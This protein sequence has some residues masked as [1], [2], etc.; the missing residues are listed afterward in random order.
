M[1]TQDCCF[2]LSGNTRKACWIVTQF[3]N[4]DCRY[5]A[6]SP[7]ACTREACEPVP[8]DV[9]ARIAQDCEKA[10]VDKIL[11]SGGEPLLVPNLVEIVQSLSGAGFAVSL[12]TNATL[13]R[14]YVLDLLLDAGLSGLSIGVNVLRFRRTRHS[15]DPWYVAIL[16]WALSQVEKRN[17]PYKL[18]I[19]LLPEL[20]RYLS[21][22]AEWLAKRRPVSINLIEPQRCGKLAKA[23]DGGSGWTDRGLG[24]VANRLQELVAPLGITLVLPRCQFPDCPSG[25]QVLG[26]WLDGMVGECPWKRYY[27]GALSG[28]S[29]AHLIT[30]SSTADGR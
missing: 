19:V 26:I 8:A 16:T 11:L 28:L 30:A 14:G 17:L 9:V 25:K 10:Q 3:C 6:S 2:R 29:D 20:E 5:C 24:D 18:N 13:V 1:K 22:V 21:L 15:K 4:L 12:C 23:A 27:H 7:P